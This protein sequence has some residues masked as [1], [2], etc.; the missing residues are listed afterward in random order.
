MLAGTASVSAV[1]PG[2]GSNG[3]ASGLNVQILGGSAHVLDNGIL[4]AQANGNTFVGLYIGFSPDASTGPQH[5][6]FTTPDYMYVLPSGFSITRAGPPTVTGVSANADGTVAVTGTNWAADSLI[7]FDGLPAAVSSLDA[8]AGVA[9]A[10]PP[11]GGN[12]QTST[13]TVYNTDGQNSQLV[14]SAS[15]VTWSYGNAASAAVGAISPAS[16]PAGAEAAV[17]IVGTGLAL[18]S[19]LTTVG[20]GT[21]DALVRQVFVLSPNHLKANV[22]IAP[23]AA[24][25]NPDVSVISGFRTATASAGFRIAAPVTGLPVAVPIIANALPGL[26]GSYAGAVI[27][28]Y[29]SNLATPGA[30]PV[31]TFNGQ[32]ATLLYSSPTQINL[33]IPPSLTAGPVALNVNNG[34]ANSYPVIV[35]IDTPPAAIG[36]VQNASGGNIDSNHPAHP[37]DAL[38]V[39]LTNFAPNGANIA[40]A[41]VQIGVGGVTHSA[42]QISYAGQG[43][44][45]VSFALNASEAPGAAQALIVYLDGRSSYPA[46]IPVAPAGT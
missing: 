23:N 42:T 17:D 25:S 19:G 20:F 36:A 30:T 16:L 22:W 4:P 12:G 1:G 3:Q 14:Q 15:P 11:P 24:L 31:V 35:N 21:T 46:A 13:V 33:Q 2:L 18:T 6:V 32:A 26:T 45:Q 37:G 27:A 34:A 28:L 5:V 43:V 29:G 7:Y 9:A 39:S 44:Y 38:I 41:R 10:T 40:L 8:K